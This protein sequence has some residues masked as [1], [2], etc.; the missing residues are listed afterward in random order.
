MKS[1]DELELC[2][3]DTYKVWR[4]AQDEFGDIDFDNVEPVR[5]EPTVKADDVLVMIPI[6]V[7]LANGT[8]IRGIAEVNGDPPEICPGISLCIEDKWFR[9][10]LPPAVPS[11]VLEK[12]G[13]AA[14]AKFLNL[15]EDSIFPIKI[16]TEVSFAKTGEPLSTK[17]TT[18]GMQ[19][20]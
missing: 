13:P 9:L 3:F 12:E 19:N 7:Y 17:L 10:M 11:F 15:R 18:S 4:L 6:T 2:D 8:S 20:A 1:L 14:F 16:Q 5:A